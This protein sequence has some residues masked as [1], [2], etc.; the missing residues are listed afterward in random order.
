MNLGGENPW[1]GS[2]GYSK[3]Q[4]LPWQQACGPALCQVFFSKRTPEAGGGPEFDICVTLSHLWLW[5]V[6]TEGERSS[7]TWWLLRS[8]CYSSPRSNERSSNHYGSRP[9]S[10]STVC[11]SIPSGIQDHMYLFEIYMP[12]HS[13]K[14][15]PTWCTY[16][17]HPLHPISI[18]GDEISKFN[19]DIF[20]IHIYVY[21]CIYIYVYEGGRGFRTSPNCILSINHLIN[22]ISILFNAW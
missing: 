22:W 5:A 2:R 14:A 21:V 10:G 11:H 6:V 18:I 20:F 16:L 9:L 3:F 13:L 8:D 4:F 1:V 12:H 7:V 17:Q 19:N 15:D